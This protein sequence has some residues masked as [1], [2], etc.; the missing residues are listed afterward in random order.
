MIKFK[1][2]F[3][4]SVAL[5]AATVAAFFVSWVDMEVHIPQNFVAVS[6][7]EEN[8]DNK[9]AF[10]PLSNK[11]QRQ[12]NMPPI[13]PKGEITP[14]NDEKSIPIPPITKEDTSDGNRES[15]N[16][17]IAREAALSDIRSRTEIIVPLGYSGVK[18]DENTG[19][20]S[21]EDRYSLIRAAI[22]RAKIY[23]LL[24]RKRKIEGTV[25]TGFRID[26]KGRPQDLKIEKSGSNT[27]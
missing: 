18:R 5:H 9:S 21:D 11:Q 24:A 1:G 8:K 4:I 7:F 15:M 25:V 6:L 10:R 27:P 12:E 13:D 2:N 3:V 20:T 19:T 23:P 22:S 14:R 16:V 17:S 26:E